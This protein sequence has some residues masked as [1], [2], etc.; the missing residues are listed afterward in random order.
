MSGAWR[1]QLQRDRALPGHDARVLE[2][3]DGLEAALGREVAQQRLAVLGVAVV[4]DDLGAERE[5]P[6]ALDRAARRAA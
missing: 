4:V 3:V 5:R 6:L 1:E 2:R